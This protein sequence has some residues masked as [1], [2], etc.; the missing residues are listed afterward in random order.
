[1]ARVFDKLINGENRDATFQWDDSF[2]DTN[3]QFMRRIQESAVREIL[4]RTKGGKMTG[5]DGFSTEA[6]R[7]LGD[8]SIVWI[9]KF[10]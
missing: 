5:P 7:Y 6:R 1:M 10:S 3:K 9:T 4:K 8:I 2:N